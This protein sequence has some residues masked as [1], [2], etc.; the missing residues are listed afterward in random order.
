MQAMRGFHGLALAAGGG[1]VVG[2]CAQASSRR[3]LPAH[4]RPAPAAATYDAVVVGGGVVGLSVLRELSVHGYKVALIE[5]EEHLVAGA[6]SS[7]NSGL[8][9]STRRAAAQRRGGA[10]SW[11][12]GVAAS[13]WPSNPCAEQASGAR[14]MTPQRG[15]WSERC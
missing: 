3:A 12:R 8:S 7:G 13:N 6:A 11:R 15:A 14:G 4:C 2:L 10:A 9:V 1:L 5:K